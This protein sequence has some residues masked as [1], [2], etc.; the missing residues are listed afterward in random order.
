M[1]LRHFGSFMAASPVNPDIK[2]IGIH[3][4]STVF[5]NL[6]LTTVANPSNGYGISTSRI[7]GGTWVFGSSVCL[8]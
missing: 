7:R 8:K 1:V 4:Y 2:S 5:C 3:S 6:H